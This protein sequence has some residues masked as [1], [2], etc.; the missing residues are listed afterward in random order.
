MGEESDFEI[1]CTHAGNVTC[2]IYIPSVS[3]NHSMADLGPGL[4]GGRTALLNPVRHRPATE[5]GPRA[6]WDPTMM[7]VPGERSLNQPGRSTLPWL[8]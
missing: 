4:V 5:T 1:R 2:M 6:P 7:V 8:R 3:H